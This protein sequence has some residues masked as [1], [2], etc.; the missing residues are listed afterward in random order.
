MG[1]TVP[2]NHTVFLSHSG[3]RRYDDYWTFDESIIFYITAN[4][5]SNALAIAHRPN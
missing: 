2:N 3:L 4:F 5:K 1:T